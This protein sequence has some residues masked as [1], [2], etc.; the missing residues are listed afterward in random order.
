MLAIKLFWN[1]IAIPHTLLSENKTM[2]I[3][4]V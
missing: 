2:N 4:A 3:M 1:F